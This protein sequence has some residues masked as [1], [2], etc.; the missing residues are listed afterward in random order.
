MEEFYA[1]DDINIL[2]NYL[3]LIKEKKISF[4]LLCSG[5]AAKD[6]LQICKNCSF[7]KEVIIFCMNKSNHDH[8]IN[9]YPGF[10]KKV[11]TSINSVYDYKKAFGEKYKYDIEL[12]YT[13]KK[14]RFSNDEISKKNQYF[15]CLQ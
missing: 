7:V 5:S 14:Y 15:Q 6:S 10:V 12:S 3:E 1:I 4:I 9:D 8:Y 2:R 11:L 13:H